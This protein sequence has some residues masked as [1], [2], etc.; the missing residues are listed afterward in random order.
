MA[1][2]PSEAPNTPQAA[3]ADAPRPRHDDMDVGRDSDA[4][5]EAN[6]ELEV[7]K[8][9]KTSRDSYTVSK[10]QSSLRDASPL[11]KPP[12]QCAWD[13]EKIPPPTP[14]P[15]YHEWVEKYGSTQPYNPEFDKARYLATPA[16]RH[17][18]RTSSSRTPG[19]VWSAPSQATT[20]SCPVEQRE[21][22]EA[23]ADTFVMLVP[24]GGGRMMN[25]QGEH[26]AKTYGE[27]LSS[28]HF[29]SYGGKNVNNK[30]WSFAVDLS[31]DYGDSL[32]GFLLDQQHFAVDSARSFSIH[33]LRSP[34][35]D[36][37][38][39]IL[40]ISPY[41]NDPGS[42]HNDILMQ[43]TVI[44]E[45]A[46]ARLRRSLDFCE[47]IG[48]LAANN[49]SH[50]GSR[51]QMI[52]TVLASYH[53]ELAT[54]DTKDGPKNTF[55][56]LGRPVTKTRG[57]I[58][59]LRETLVKAICGVSGDHFYVG[60]HK[61]CV[62]DE[63]KPGAPSIDCK[64]CKS[65]VHRTEDCPLPS[66][67]GWKGITPADLRKQEDAEDRARAS[68]VRDDSQAI[69]NDLLSRMRGDAPAKS[70]AQDDEAEEP[71]ASGE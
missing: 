14:P 44:M 18:T 65:D 52:N 38:K 36:S 17:A 5:T 42:S 64:L 58:S 19:P 21:M 23:N 60:A 54:A 29:A 11:R 32:W 71:R 25:T 45:T 40:F 34:E 6:G 46:K 28:F 35:P 22:V 33:T 16:Y 20:P 13:R 39:L 12:T 57:E 61:V 26:F 59:Q 31:E 49:I 43:R 48:K 41:I 63:T 24:H 56:L 7:V 2:R 4:E 47:L 30:P 8:R 53:L 55:V 1:D 68:R 51:E 27:Y 66:A 10:T 69:M 15:E 67:R 62:Y 70:S 9:L 3:T 37:W 50:T